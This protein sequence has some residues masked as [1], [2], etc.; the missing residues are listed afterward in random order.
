MVYFIYVLS[1]WFTCCTPRFMPDHTYRGIGF[2]GIEPES[3]RPI[4]PDAPPM[5]PC[6]DQREDVSRPFF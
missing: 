4:L 6:P 2:F 5:H 1:N 3:P